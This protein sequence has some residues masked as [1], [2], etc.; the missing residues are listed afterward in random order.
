MKTLFAKFRI[1]TALDLRRPTGELARGGLAGSEELRRFGEDVASLDQAL[2]K[3]TPARSVPPQLHGSIM[4]AIRDTERMATADLSV[5]AISSRGGALRRMLAHGR[6]PLA[7]GAFA[8]AVG[9]LLCWIALRPSAPPVRP[10][11]LAAASTAVDLGSQMPQV[12]PS[13]VIAP[14]S[15]ELDRI[16]SDC[17]GGVQAV[18]ASM[19]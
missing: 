10:M 15:D 16:E 18:L 11:S 1:S 14:L 6:S 7:A 2:K 9:I 13:D 4:D 5:G 17:N 3:A 8:G 19:P 12:V